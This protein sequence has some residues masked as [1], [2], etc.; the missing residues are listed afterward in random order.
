MTEETTPFTMG[1][2]LRATAKHIR[3][4]IDISIRKTN[5]R[6]PEFKDNPEKSKE[7]MVTLMRLHSIRKMLDEFQEA[8]AAD[9]KEK[10]DGR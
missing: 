5:D 8:H 2:V 4:S 10:N 1:Y 9:F 7:V 3:K 6:W